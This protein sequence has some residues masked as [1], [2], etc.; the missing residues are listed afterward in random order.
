MNSIT[1][2]Y[3]N[4]RDKKHLQKGI[5]LCKIIRN[6]P[7]NYGI[8]L[9]D[10]SEKELTELLQGSKCLGAWDMEEL[11]GLG[12]LVLDK[13]LTKDHRDLLKLDPETSMAELGVYVH[14]NHCNKG[15]AKTFAE[16]LMN[17]ARE[18]GRNVITATARVENEPSIRLLAHLGFVFVT[19]YDRG[20]GHKR[21]LYRKS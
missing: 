6:A 9:Y 20:D 14:Q 18:I 11:V 21:N 5:E 16:K 17:Y 3:L 4:N 8:F 13:G 12:I 1:Y 7:D 19:E 2:S 15:I 10:F